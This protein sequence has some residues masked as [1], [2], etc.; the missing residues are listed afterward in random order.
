MIAA[1]M[2]ASQACRSSRIERD[3]D[4]SCMKEPKYRFAPFI[5]YLIIFHA[6]WMGAYVFWIYPW[7]KSFGEATLLYALINITLRLLIW[8]LPVFLYLRYVDHKHP[9]EYLKL[10][11]H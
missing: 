6:F 10:D 3:L 4:L 7:M 1:F 2:T 11:Q 8:V 5:A 9:I